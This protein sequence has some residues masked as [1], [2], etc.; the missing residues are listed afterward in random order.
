MP[1]CAKFGR[2]C[3]RREVL[4][5]SPS[6]LRN[7]ECYTP[8]EHVPPVI[9]VSRRRC[10]SIITVISCSTRQAADIRESG[11][12]TRSMVMAPKPGSAAASTKG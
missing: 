5:T 4:D 6:L 2:L 1:S 12:R 9:D 10:A 3:L 11:E 8:Y 7:V